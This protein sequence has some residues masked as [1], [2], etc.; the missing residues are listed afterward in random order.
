MGSDTFDDFLL[1]RDD[2]LAGDICD[3][4]IRRFGDHPA[5][6]PGRAGE[7][8][9]RSV[10]DSLDLDISDRPEFADL[11]PP[12]MQAVFSALLAYLRRYPY[13]L[14]ASSSIARLDPGTDVSVPLTADDLSAMSDPALGSLAN[15]FFRCGEVTLQMYEQGRG[16]YF[17]WHTE[18]APA[19]P[20]GEKLHRVLPWMVYLNDV[21]DGGETEWLHQRRAVTPRRGRLAMWPAYFTHTHRG[22]VPRSS[23]KHIVTSWVLFQRAR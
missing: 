21:A 10:K 7:Q 23:D 19:D 3:E 22:Q 17:A 9:N 18:M 4:F 14:L 6:A 20:T 12:L 8:V 16:G 1:L 15:R 2:A 11:M 5:R 13:T